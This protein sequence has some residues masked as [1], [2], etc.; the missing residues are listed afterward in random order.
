[1][2]V[3]IQ[4]GQTL[5]LVGQSGCGKSTCMQLLQRYYDTDGGQVLVDGHDTRKTN[6]KFLR[7]QIG[8][9]AQEP[10]LFDATI[11]ENI[12]YGCLD[13]ELSQE[14]VIRASTMA[15]LHDFIKDMPLGY[16][17]PAGT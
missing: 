7:S 17:T 14:E 4:P 3:S 13:K 2:D 6:T 8:I 16:D 9:V 12:R 11:G 1:M 10:T 15:S 5:A